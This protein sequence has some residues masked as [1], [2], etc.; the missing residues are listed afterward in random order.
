MPLIIVLITYMVHGKWEIYVP[1]LS[2]LSSEWEAI[3]RK[4]ISRW[5]HVPQLKAI[6]FNSW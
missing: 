1:L 2:N 5:Q 3:N 4:Q 6:S